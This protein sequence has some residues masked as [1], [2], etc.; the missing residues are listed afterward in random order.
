MAEQ[1]HLSENY[2]NEL[3]FH[4]TPYFTHEFVYIFHII[5][6]INSLF[7]SLHLHVSVLMCHPQG[8]KICQFS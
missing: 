3:F 5:I 7:I 8:K 4:L 1:N 2:I 6:T